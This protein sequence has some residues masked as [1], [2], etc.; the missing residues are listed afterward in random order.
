MLFDIRDFYLHGISTQQTMSHP[1]LIKWCTMRVGYTN[2][3]EKRENLYVT[4]N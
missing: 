3:E 1:S 4:E 2:K